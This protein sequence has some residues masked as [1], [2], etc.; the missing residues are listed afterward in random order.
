MA[1]NLTFGQ[2]AGLAGLSGLLSF[3]G[4]LATSA[5]NSSRAWKYTQ[6]AM[7]YQDQLNRAFTR[8]S[9][10]LMREG[11]ETAGYNPLLALGSGA[12]SAIYSGSGANS[13]SDNGSQAVASAI[14]A[15]RIKNETKLAKTQAKVNDSQAD[16]NTQLTYKALADEINA[17]S[18]SA[19]QNA[20]EQKILNDIY[21]DNETNREIIKRIHA[22]TKYTNERSRG[23]SASSS[24][25]YG[26][27]ISPNVSFDKKKGRAGFGISG[28]GNYS[29]S[30]SKSW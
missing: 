5:I 1:S 6:R 24:K 3:G 15:L 8:D 27:S 2:Q 29:E 20:T 9:Y 26:G 25:S 7:S 11:L 13:D 4:N 28:S 30:N 14:D 22:E 21:W 23:F 12:N 18:S 16:L 17:R 19:V 10:G